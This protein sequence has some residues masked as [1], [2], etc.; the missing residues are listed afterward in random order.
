MEVKQLILD[1]SKW[2]CGD[3]GENKIGT[4]TTALLNDQGFMCCLGQWCHQLGAP[5]EEL[6]NL[7]EPQ[8]AKTTIDL[9]VDVEKHNYEYFCP[10]KGEYVTEEII[11]GKCGNTLSGDCITVND[12]AES[13]PDEKIDK[14][15]EL[16]AEK[17]IS[18]KVINQ[19]H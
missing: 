17:G 13:T 10:E 11:D 7:G 15:T 5:L 19:P 2:R 12:N 3:D 14:L 6:L 18:L 16:L 8:E 1:Y 4:G 9:F